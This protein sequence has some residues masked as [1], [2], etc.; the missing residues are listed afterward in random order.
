MN[1]TKKKKRQH[2]YLRVFIDIFLISNIKDFVKKYILYRKQR[3]YLKSDQKLKNL[4][5]YKSYFFL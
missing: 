5:M 3:L 1:F 4:I 2:L